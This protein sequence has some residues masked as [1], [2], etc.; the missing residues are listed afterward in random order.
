METRAH[1]VLVGSFVLLLMAGMVGFV[2]W[3][4]KFQFDTE[5]ARYDI[6]ITGSVT[7]LNVGSPARYNGV[8]VGEVIDVALDP[9]APD[10]VVVTIEIDAATPVKSDTTATLE[11]EGLT[12]GR[13]LLLRGGSADAGPPIVQ[14]G[15]ERPIIASSPSS[16]E[17][18]LAGAPELVESVNLLL[19]RANDLLNDENRL[20]IASSFANM[21]DLT[22][23]LVDR[24]EELALLIDDASGTM[25][26]LRNASAAVETLAVDMQRD[27]VALVR[28]AN[29]T[30]SAFETTASAVDSAVA[31][32]AADAQKLIAEFGKTAR[33]LTVATEQIGA[34]VKE[35][36]RPISDFTGTGL[37]EL[38]TLLIEMRELVVTLNRVTTEVQRDPARFLFGDQHQGYEPQ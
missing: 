35:N 10:Q 36:R 9:A 1:T 25:T 31:D 4:A 14:P 38:S 12:G 2:L 23:L 21:R 3:L 8:R 7:G 11:I 34:M 37:Y 5:L 6:L 27:G 29:A 19:V 24:S 26:N 32:T 20:A 13:Y 17:Q 33:A 22:G 16:L 15:R 30:L 18:V 28:Q